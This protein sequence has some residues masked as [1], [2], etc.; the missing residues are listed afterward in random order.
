M[1]RRRLHYSRG[2]RRV[3]TQSIQHSMSLIGNAPGA[4]VGLAHV[5][6]HAQGLAGGSMT[7]SRTGGEDRTT[8]VD[9][10]RSVGA[11]TI[12]IG[13]IPL[14]ASQGYYEFALVKYERSFTTPAWGTDPVPGNA[15]V[16]TDGLQREARSLTPGYVVQY[17][18]I[19]ITAEINRTKKIIVNWAK[20]K[21][22]KVRDGDY[23]VLLI[24]NRTA[25]AGV[26]DIHCRYRTYGS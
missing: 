1:R 15:N 3:P 2:T 10:G 13:F 23:F 26:Y 7:A 4:N 16:I 20:F 19:P 21:K 5:L 18:L 14:G 22:A 17:G 25:A 6:A 24:F 9:N 12:D 11:M 8:E